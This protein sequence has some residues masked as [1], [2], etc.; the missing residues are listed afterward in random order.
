MLKR[1]YNFGMRLYGEF[2]IH[3]IEM[4]VEI[5]EFLGVLVKMRRAMTVAFAIFRRGFEVEFGALQQ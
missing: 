5:Y 2:V 1:A 4:Y 3:R